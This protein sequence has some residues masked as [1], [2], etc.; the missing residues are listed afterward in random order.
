MAQYLVNDYPLITGHIRMAKSGVWTAYDVLVDTDVAFKVGDS[1][2]MKLIDVTFNG[3][4]YNSDV[5]LGFQ[6]CTILGGSGKL[7]TYL[8]SA[9]YNATT[10]GQVLKDIARNTNHK[11]STK[12]EQNV[13]NFSL[14]GWNILKMKAALAIEKLTSVTSCLCRVLPDGTL[15][16]GKETYTPVNDDD[17]LVIEKFPDEGR[18]SIYNDQTLIQPL[19]SLQGMNIVQVDYL[20]QDNELT[21]DIYFS[22]ISADSVQELTEQDDKILYEGVYRCKVVKQYS[23]GNLELL[24]DPNFDI[25]R[26]GFV[27]VPIIYP[28][29]GMKITVPI[30]TACYVGFANGN[31]QFPRVQ[32]WD[33]N[34]EATRVEF[35]HTNMLA[36]ARKTDSVGFFAH[37]PASGAGVTP[38]SL[39]Y[40]ATIPA[41]PTWVDPPIVNPGEVNI[42]TGSSKVFIG[43]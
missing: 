24:P 9:P 36:A 17:Y 13:L 16:F 20:V 41:T 4:I 5:Y 32:G 11:I 21:T 23:T 33:D 26:N 27:D 39:Q 6:R 38:C 42:Q 25:I 15:W 8:E 19:S 14:T 31:P 40:F 18:W 2:T 3:T 29:P 37:V 34:G 35:I 30:G 12:A 10:I 43:S 22:D 28:F 7:S 1:V